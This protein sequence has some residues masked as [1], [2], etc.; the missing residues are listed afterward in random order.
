MA[1]WRTAHLVERRAETSSAG[2]LVLEIDD[3]PGQVAGQHVDIRLTAEDGY[4]AA[5]S[6]S[7]ASA[8]GGNRIELTVQRVPDGEVSPYLLDTFNVGDPIEV[9][10]PVGGWF[11]WH[12]TESAPVLLV[13][14][15]SGIAPIM[16]MIRA[17]RANGSDAP[18]RLIYS[19]RTDR[20]V[21]FT[22]ELRQRVQDDE[23]LDV[24][25]VY[26]RQAPAGWSEQ[27][28]RLSAADIR[29]HGWSPDLQPGVFRVRA[30]RTR[31]G[32]RRTPG[33]HRPRL[34]TDQDRTVRPYRRLK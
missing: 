11:V 14:G 3:W 12:P 32:R 33:G 15:G 31:G 1:M 28:H 22:D 4:Q 24:T 8:P 16:A 27:P 34:S 13:A 25:Y 2:T 5:R 19:V 29:N 9:R 21:Y 20:D 18:F 26:T 6:Y 7:I 23:G 17:R 10:G 30:H